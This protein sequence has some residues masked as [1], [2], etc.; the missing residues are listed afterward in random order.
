MRDSN[1]VGG[2]GCAGCRARRLLLTLRKK[3][4]EYENAME[5][6]QREVR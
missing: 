4:E 6:L 5:K 1:W 3:K 2:W